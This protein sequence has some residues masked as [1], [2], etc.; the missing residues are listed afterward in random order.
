[1]LHT[2]YPLPQSLAGIIAQDRFDAWLEE[3]ASTLYH[4]DLNRKRPCAL[5]GSNRLYRDKIYD[6]VLSQRSID[7]FTGQPLQWD[8]ILKW[9]PAK[10]IGHN[11]FMKE[12]CLLPTVDHKDPYCITVDFEICSWIVNGCKNDQT[13]A[14]FIDMC[15]IITLHRRNAAVGTGP[16]GKEPRFYFLPDFLKGL[17]QEAVYLKWLDKRAEQLYVRDRDQGR[18]YG[19]CGSKGSYK[20][21]IHATVN[22]SGLCDPYTGQTMKWEL[23]G[24]WEAHCG[25]LNR[26]YK[27]YYLLPTIDH[28][29]PYAND[30]EL[31]ICSW[32][33]NCCKGGLTPDE[34][35]SLCS[36]VTTHVQS[37]GNFLKV[38]P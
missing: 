21:A 6:A 2:Q 5:A 36:A 34:F 27:D 23:I 18:P 7:P 10:N 9:D 33:I 26:A 15:R 22:A 13:P 3:R 20:R 30:L 1:M 29:N 38:F 8:L 37:C 32:R 31:E 14:E 25:T 35:V 19:L 11:D 16:Y 12:F 17:C 4:R 28:A 24:T